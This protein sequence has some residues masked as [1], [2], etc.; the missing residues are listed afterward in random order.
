MKVKGLTIIAICLVGL[1]IWINF[2]DFK[3][4]E[5]VQGT[6]IKSEYFI[7]TISLS[8]LAAYI[9][10]VLNIYLV[11]KREKKS[12]LP[13]VAKKVIGIIVNN[14]S[15]INCITEPSK[16]NIN[17]DFYPTPDDYKVLLKSINPKENAPLFFKTKS[18]FFLFKNRQ[19]STQNS[20]D[21][22]W[23]SGKHIDEELRRILL[24]ISSSL[25]LK[26][27]YAF[28]SEDFDDENLEKYHLVISNYFQLIQQL[29]NYYD[30]NLKKYYLQTLPKRLRK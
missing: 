11:E 15:I 10:Y 27:N 17:L 2:I 20:I 25:Y 8:Y 6:A 14:H 7:E 24:E 12:I 16:I 26:E 18:W 21:K 1:L 23:L 9:F 22:I 3:F 4:D 30:I 5:I 13:F 19:E 28:N 29:K